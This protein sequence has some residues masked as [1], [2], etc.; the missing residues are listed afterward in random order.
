MQ[1]A[2]AGVAIERSVSYWWN[3][4]ELHEPGRT[5]LLHFTDMRDQPWL[6]W[7]NPRA[8]HWC[9]ALRVA[10][11]AGDVAAAA[12]AEHAARGW[13]RPSLVE[14]LAR[15]YDD[16]LLLD[17]RLLGAEQ[18]SFLPPHMQ[19]AAR[20]LKAATG[21][22]GPRA[23]SVRLALRRLLARARFVAA[24]LGLVRV[25]RGVRMAARKLHH[26]LRAGR[27]RE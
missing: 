1:G 27:Q 26:A 12:V 5:R 8:E 14:Q 15:G 4:L 9:A 3:S 11:D 24:R 2:L 6:S 19:P 7:R 21:F 16:P 20:W 17:A 18:A 22:G 25:V 23:G 10:I 13:L